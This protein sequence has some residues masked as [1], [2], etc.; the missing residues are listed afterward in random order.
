MVLNNEN[1]IGGY[2]EILD[3][4]EPPKAFLH[5]DDTGF[6]FF[7]GEDNNPDLRGSRMGRLTN[8]GKV[9]GWVLPSELSFGNRGYVYDIGTEDLTILNPVPPNGNL[10][11]AHGINSSGLIVGTA[12]DEPDKN[13]FRRA[14]RWPVGS[15]D[16]EFL[17]GFDNINARFDD[18]SAAWVGEDG[19][20]RGNAGNR[21][22]DG[23]LFAQNLP[24]MWDPD[25]QEVRILGAPDGLDWVKVRGQ[26]S[27]GLM[28][29]GFGYKDGEHSNQFFANHVGVIWTEDTGWIDVNS[30]IVGGPADYQ[31]VEVTGISDNGTLC[32]SAIN[33][34]GNIEAVR[35]SSAC[36]T[37]DVDQIVVDQPATF[38][39]ANGTPGARAAVL[40]GF[41]GTPSIFHQVNGWCATFGFD[42]RLAKTKIR[43]AFTGIFDRDG[44]L[45]RERTVRSKVRGLTIMFQAAENG[46][47]PEECMSNIVT[48]IAE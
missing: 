21:D 20:V 47:C 16:A 27:D 43:V 6:D 19:I 30:L 44:R 32:G 37:L 33:A 12:S 17:P 41:G 45:V 34:D 26:N 8:F 7:V 40:A 3:P 4:F 5:H 15:T 25:T 13:G 23:V 1:Q 46:T 42:A 48:R 29:G 18:V 2:A 10:A 36:L 38:T 24:W 9:V 28:L 22:A 31:I 11:L 14:V 39:L 35:L